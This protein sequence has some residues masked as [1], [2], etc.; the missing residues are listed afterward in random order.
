MSLKMPPVEKIYEAWSAIASGRVKIMSIGEAGEAEVASS[1]GRK[2]YHVEWRGNVYASDDSATYW[3]GYPGY[4][5]IAIMM[6][7]GK[8][9]YCVE[10]AE[11]FKNVD[12]NLFNSRH[13]RDYAAALRDAL[14]S[15]DIGEDERKKAAEEARMAEKDL[16]ESGI[17]LARYRKKE[18]QED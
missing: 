16:K 10:C 6:V 15:L 1:N 5:V 3:Q 11:L 8:L 17:G 13:R 18:K 7:Q 9:P 4:P 12:W 2:T 14:D